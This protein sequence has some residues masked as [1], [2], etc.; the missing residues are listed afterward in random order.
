MGVDVP[1]IPREREIRERERAMSLDVQNEHVTVFTDKNN[2]N[3]KHPLQNKWALW[4]D[5][6]QKK[7]NANN[8]EENLKRITTIEYVEDFWAVFN[9]VPAATAL[10]TGSN[11]HLFKDGIRPTWED[12]QN[13]N[14]GKWVFQYKDRK[15]RFK[16]LDTMWL[17]T[18]L[19]MI[20]ETFADNS[21]ITGAVISV[22]KGVDR[23]AMWTRTASSAEE[24]KRIGAQFKEIMGV[25]TKISYQAHRD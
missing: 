23:I 9:N 7:T 18:M 2:F 21:E 17:H 19:G 12:V 14:G 25:S 3:V 4:W 5:S 11:Y 16:M 6:A 13:E 15:E 20:G 8:W 10:V 22:R 24:Q 1:L